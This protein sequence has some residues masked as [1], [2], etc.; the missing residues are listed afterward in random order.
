MNS[1]DVGA[2]FSAAGKDGTLSKG[3]LSV[4]DAEDIGAVINQGLGITPDDITASEVNNVFMLLDDSSSI[5]H[6]GNT[7]HVRDGHNLIV[8][9]LLKTK[10][11]DAI[12]MCGRA[13]NRGQIYPCVRLP[14]VPR[15]DASNYNPSGGTPLYD[16]STIILGMAAA[17]HQ[18]FADNGVPCRTIVPIITDGADVGS[19]KQR[20]DHVR[21]IVQDLLRTEQFIVIGVGIDDG[22][23]NF[24]SVFQSMGI[25]DRWIL[26]PGNSPSEIRKAFAMVSQ[27]VSRA[28][29]NAQ[30]FSTA[31]MGGFAG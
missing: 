20:P 9:S 19:R 12:I 21:T 13:L 11:A 5:E 16:E 1:T 14:D 15:L 30:A 8:D 29:Q 6:A 31:A 24:R 28:S 18:Q 17:K 2:L 27:S 23:T 7:Q 26:T 10:Q 4:L 25:D 22:V 3:A